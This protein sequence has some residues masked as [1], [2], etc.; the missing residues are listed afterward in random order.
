[1]DTEESI[2]DFEI[3]DNGT[4]S[5]IYKDKNRHFIIYYYNEKDNLVNE[6][7]YYS[8]FYKKLFQDNIRYLK[9]KDDHIM[10]K[11]IQSSYFAC[12]ILKMDDIND[13]EF[14]DGNTL[15]CCADNIRSK[16]TTS[17]IDNICS[18]I[19]CK[20]RQ[21]KGNSKNYLCQHN[22]LL[23]KY[24]KLCEEW[25]YDKNKL[26]PENY[27]RG[28]RRKVFW[29]C[30]K[31]NLGINLCKCHRWET[32]IH[33]RTTNKRGCP[34]CAGK[35]VCPHDNL[36]TAFPELCLE[37]NYE[38]NT[39]KP[40]DYL[41]FS[42]KK[43]WWKCKNQDVCECHIWES[44][45]ANRTVGKNG[46]PFC[47]GR[48][49]KHN[50]ITITH[51]HLCLEW[52]YDKNKLGP[53]NYTLGSHAKI[54]WTCIL[55]LCGCHIWQT[56][57]NKRVAGGTNC[58]FCD[59]KNL[60]KHNNLLV[61]E[62]E[63]CLEWDY[64]K[65]KIKPEK[66][67]RCSSKNVWW[68]CSN[69]DSCE[70]H[71]WNASICNRVLK[72]TG[73]PFCDGRVG[74]KHN[75]I[76]ITHKKLCLEWDYEKNDTKPEKYTF[77]SHAKVHWVCK[78]DPTHKWSAMINKRPGCPICFL[79]PSCNL[80]RTAGNLC[81]YC[82]PAD[83]NKHYKKT[84]EMKIVRFLKEKLPD[85]EFIHNKSVGSEC[86][87]THLFPDIRVECSF[88]HIVIEIDE[89]KHRGSYYECDERRM[90]DIIA[91][92]GEPCIFIR[93]NPDN[94]LS[95]RNFLLSTIKK[96]LDLDYD[97]YVNLEYKN[98]QGLDGLKVKY[99]YY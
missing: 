75:N 4:D 71:S 52:D 15:N 54:Y 14:L 2:W 9:I 50:N 51:P 17:G 67:A 80:F 84:K 41:K 21:G 59:G 16:D 55:N 83:M 36:S 65:N 69:P 44:T 58:P 87:G 40:E 10:F 48:P 82:R 89:F 38:K 73:C 19:L 91:K 81:S 13:I 86:T 37:W 22:N 74:C 11:N 72:K 49:C 42:A 3:Y 98:W 78:K 6:I 20:K 30:K 26:A 45:I 79:C 97:K 29:I 93:Y 31:E 23:A 32:T 25:D 57:I 47:D 34:F 94:P 96:Y 18:S 7:I 60:C 28:S 1:M 27:T 90:V 92:L 12:K 35:K 8:P 68:K 63:L 53:E 5:I 39:L 85:I 88:Y 46:C 24:P 33:N 77:G 56:T 99:L 66:Y 76:T 62:K 43:V 64:D 70:C 95:D 61:L